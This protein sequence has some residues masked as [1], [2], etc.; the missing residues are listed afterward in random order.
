MTTWKDIAA[1]EVQREKWRQEKQ[2]QADGMHWRT[3]QTKNEKR[4]LLYRQKLDLRKQAE[5]IETVS[6]ME[7][8][9][10]TRTRVVKRKALQRAKGALP[11]SPGKYVA[12]VLSL[13]DTASP[14]KK[15]SFEA[16]PSCSRQE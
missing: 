7:D 4:R 12:T 11:N 14:R 10:D 9:E 1:Q 16:S 15:R 2:K 3:R 13:I 8:S 5:A 6:S